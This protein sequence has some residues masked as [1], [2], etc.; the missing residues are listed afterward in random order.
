MSLSRTE[1]ILIKLNEEATEI[2]KDVDKALIFGLDDVEP[3]QEFTNKQKIENEIAD[4]LGVVEMLTE[5]GFLNKDEIF[6][7]SKI[8]AKKVKVLRWLDYSILK[9]ITK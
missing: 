5:K 8:N 9:G 3:N 2:A 6:N 7:H 1:H 4:L